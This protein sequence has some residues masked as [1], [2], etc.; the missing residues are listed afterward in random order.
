M[1]KKTTADDALVLDAVTMRV[2]PTPPPINLHD[3][4]AVRREMARVYRGM[5]TGMIETQDGT[6]LVY[7]LVQVAK[8]HEAVDLLRRLNKLE[9]VAYEHQ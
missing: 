6:R 1:T 9:E 5:K 8:L 3:I 2:L 4:E 7:V